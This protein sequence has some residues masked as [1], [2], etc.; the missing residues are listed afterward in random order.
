MAEGLDSSSF[1]TMGLT[2]AGVLAVGFG[3]GWLFDSLFDT[4]PIFVIVGLLLGMA[5]AVSYMIAKFRFYLHSD[6][7][8]D[9]RPDAPR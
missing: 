4:F 1:L 6:T 2:T 9:S 8:P 5:G 3:L 7:P